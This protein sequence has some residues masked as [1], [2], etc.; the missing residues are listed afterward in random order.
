MHPLRLPNGRRVMAVALATF[1]VAI[2]GYATTMA[3]LRSQPPSVVAVTNAPAVS[4]SADRPRAGAHAS[5]QAA[6]ELLRLGIAF[7]G[8]HAAIVREFHLAH[9]HVISGKADGE[10][11]H[12]YIALSVRCLRPSPL[13]VR[14]TAVFPCHT[15]R[16]GTAGRLT[17]RLPLATRLWVREA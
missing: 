7:A 11:Y 2:A 3:G 10:A 13:T 5:Q 15:R 14:G 9:K 8:E 6:S 4:S 12:M 17:L 16:F 1:L